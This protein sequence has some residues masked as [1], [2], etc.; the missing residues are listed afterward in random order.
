MKRAS[1]LLGISFAMLTAASAAIDFTPAPGERELNGIKFPQLI[2]NDSGRQ[3]IY[4]RPRGWTYSGGGSSIKF[5]PPQVGQAEGEIQQLPLKA[6]QIF[7]EP[8][9]TALQNQTLAAVPSGSTD[10]ALVSEQK[11]PIMVN[12][13]HTYEVV[14]GYRYYGQDYQLSILFIN[15]P[16]LQLRMRTIAKK[17]D[18]DKVHK[19]FRSSAVSFQGLKPGSI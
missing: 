16:D 5:F 13:N 8:T 4:E 1:A 9:V 3:V 15:L 11:D 17:D 12:G 10:V 7:D 14:V 19:A 18:F 2:F 6:P